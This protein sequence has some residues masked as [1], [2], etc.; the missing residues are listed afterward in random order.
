MNFWTFIKNLFYVPGAKDPTASV[1]PTVPELPPAVASSPTITGHF[2]STD[3]TV[4]AP[5]YD[6]LFKTLVI[7]SRWAST[8]KGALEA[9][10]ANRPRYGM[11]QGLTGVPWYVIACIHYRESGLDFTTC[12]HNGDPLPGPT[13]DVPAGR[14]PFESWE[15]A[16]VDALQF[17][18]LDKVTDWSL[19]SCLYQCELYNGFGYRTRHFADTIPSGASPYIWNG[20]QWYQSGCYVSDHNFSSTKVDDNLGVAVLLKALVQLGIKQN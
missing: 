2:Q 5:E 14:G 18:G 8:L 20:S 6:A 15:A 19:A 11:V 12:L 3:F 4:L 16:A 1:P 17:D 10:L 13:T 7:G 9:I